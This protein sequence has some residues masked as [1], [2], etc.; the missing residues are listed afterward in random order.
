MKTFL[1][2]TD[3]SAA[4]R[5]A[6]QYG[7]ELARAFNGRVIL[8]NA[9]QPLPVVATDSLVTAMPVDLGE[10]VKQQLEAEADLFSSERATRLEIVAKEGPVAD[11]ILGAA[12][13]MNADLILAGMKGAG[14]T[15]RKL[16]G[17]TVTSLAKK[18][19]IPVIVIPEGVSYRD[20]ATIAL[21]NDISSQS[22]THLLDALR[23]LVEKFHSKLYVV[24]VVTKR[25]NEVVEVL[26]R[27][28]NLKT[29]VAD[30]EPLFEFPVDKNIDKALSEF[31]STHHVDLLAMVPHKE[32]L[33]ERWFL[34]SNTK[35]MIFKT[36]IP[37]LVLPEQS[38]RLGKHTHSVLF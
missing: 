22:G 16:F 1:I 20:P 15:A 24:R 19:A 17:S 10:L 23:G 31:V 36:N 3:F 18:S 34:R 21:A 5:N 35:E 6:T 32:S 7:I 29:M 13:E 38:H 28:W 2:A 4:S 11:T 8:L 14:K 26:N 25:S 30:L 9:Y 27:P 33:P 12:K 37:L